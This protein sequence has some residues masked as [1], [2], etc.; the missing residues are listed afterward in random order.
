MKPEKHNLW[1][2]QKID[3]L[4][5]V[6]LQN[7]LSKNHL[8][9]TAVYHKSTPVTN[10]GRAEDAAALVLTFLEDSNCLHKVAVMASGLNR[11]HAKVKMKILLTLLILALPT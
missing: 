10:C 3:F 2:L 6:F 11:V 9:S 7:S 8:G 1:L 4:I 5:P